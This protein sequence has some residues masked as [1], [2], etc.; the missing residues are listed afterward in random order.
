MAWGFKSPGGHHR[1]G[2]PWKAGA[3]PLAK[4][5]DT[6]V[7]RPGHL[8]AGTHPTIRVPRT[9]VPCFSDVPAPRQRASVMRR[10]RP[11]TLFFRAD[12][13]SSALAGE[14]RM[15]RGGPDD[16]L[17]AGCDSPPAV[18]VGRLRSLDLSPR[19]PA[20]DAAGVQQI[21]C[22]SGADG[23]VRKR[24]NADRR[25]PAGGPA[26]SGALA[27]A[28]IPAHAPAP[29]SQMDR[30][31]HGTGPDTSTSLPPV[32][33]RAFEAAIGEATAFIGA[34]APNPPVGCTL[35]DEAGRPLA[36]AAHERAGQPHAEAPRPRA[37]PPGRPD[38]ARAGRRG[39]AR[40]LQ[41]HRPHAALRG[42]DPRQSRAQ[43]LVRRARPEPARR[44]QWRGAAAR[45]GARGDRA[46][47]RRGRSAGGR[48]G[49]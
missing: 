32:V 49:G 17:G 33:A 20:A 27:R 5:R 28:S 15:V 22:N 31:M 38:R 21:R 1:G 29:S 30:R 37:C 25:C 45:G 12:A 24:E 44:G 47:G 43:G 35:L 26:H 4:D 8:A 48:A 39:D 10:L 23:I 7:Q 2:H 9:T 18:W 6:G 13:P 41:P 14:R 40:A 16:V 19:A 46:R 42:G 3:L 11:A 34:T 36:S